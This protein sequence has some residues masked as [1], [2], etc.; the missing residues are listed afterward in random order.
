MTTPVIQHV[1]P[2][3]EEALHSFVGGCSC[4]TRLIV[5]PDGVMI[6]VH[7]HRIAGQPN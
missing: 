7:Q 4:G 6:V 1:Y 5:Q 3:E 2:L